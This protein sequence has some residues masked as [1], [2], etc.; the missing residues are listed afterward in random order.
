MRLGEPITMPV[1]SKNSVALAGE[2]A[3]L[4]QLALRGFD[5]N[6]TLGNTKAVDILAAHPTDGRVLK[7][8]VKTAFGNK[9][10]RSKLFGYHLG[11]VVSEKN[12][13]IEEPHLFY[14]FVSI[15]RSSYQCRFFIIH[16]SLVACYVRDQH[17]YWLRDPE[18]HHVDNPIRVFRI[19]LDEE[20][21]PVHTPLAKTH[22]NCWDFPM[23]TEMQSARSE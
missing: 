23:P 6:M 14:C 7:I 10:A 21:Y 16:S 18:Q 5:A 3:V 19:G 8:E 9:P 11:W 1:L 20:R 12:E 22:E 15:D 2:F 4:S 17:Q 13:R